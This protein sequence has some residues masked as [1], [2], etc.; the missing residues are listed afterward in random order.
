MTEKQK[1]WTTKDFA[2][3]SRPDQIAKFFNQMN[4]IIERCVKIMSKDENNV[5]AG[6]IFDQYQKN[7]FVKLEQIL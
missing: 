1:K 4:N 2:D 6:F 3:A 7:L 5:V